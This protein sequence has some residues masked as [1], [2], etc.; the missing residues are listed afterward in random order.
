M[1]ARSMES[2]E[3]AEVMRE[4][5]FVKQELS[6]IRLD[7]A[8]V[9]EVKTLAEKDCEVSSSNLWANL[10]SVEALKKEIEE[11]NEEQV[12]VELAR[13]E[14]L[15]D[16][17]EIEAEREKEASEFSF[18]MGETNKKIKGIIEEMDRSKYLQNKLAVTLYDVSV[19]QNELNLVKEMGTNRV[20]KNDSLNDRDDTFQRKEE[21]KGSAL[22]QSITEE[23]EA[24][25]QELASIKEEGF[26]FMASMDIIRNEL[27]RVSEETTRLKKTEEK[28]DYK[29]QSL[30]SKLLIANSKLEAVSAAEEKVN[31]I[32]SNL[33]LTLEQLKTESEAAKKE[34]ELIVEETAKVMVEIEKTES[35]IDLT[36]EGL[37]A[38][39]QELE[40]VRSSEAL[41][42]QILQRLREKTMKARA[43]ESEHRS[44]IIISK[45]EYD[46]LTGCANGA[47]EIADKKVVAAQAW[48]E[49]LKA[50]EKEILMKYEMANRDFREMRVEEEKE[51]RTD[52]SPSA[53]RMVE[54]ELHN[55]TGK[56]EENFEPE[57][58]HFQTS[59]KSMRA[60]FRK[61]FSPAYRMT[62][63]KNSFTMKKKVV[64]NFASFFAA[65]KKNK[66]K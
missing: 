64:P 47:E 8:S 36:E 42:L 21:L 24:A 12:L 48:I 59:R 1:E 63:S 2:Y 45:F 55:W 11:A 25:K 50:S 44:S 61:S 37:L 62:P 58:Y 16:Y 66:H 10:C 31:S 49:A 41:A 15:K 46:Y 32:V 6:K 54:G 17:S 5:E 3:Y 57:D 43:S 4:L 26:Q 39:M 13:I 40:A 19:L 7:M 35:E 23:L 22:L 38:A 28:V 20:Q 56:H 18:Q 14:A 33:T 65:K 30:N 52:G 27:K 53:K 29:V 34:E 60:K 51:H 9:L